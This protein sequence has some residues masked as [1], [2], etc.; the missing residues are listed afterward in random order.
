VEDE[1]LVEVGDDLGNGQNGRFGS[2]QSDL[3]ASVALSECKNTSGQHDQT[4]FLLRIQSMVI[5]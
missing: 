3:Y 5:V 2:V 1:K 4:L